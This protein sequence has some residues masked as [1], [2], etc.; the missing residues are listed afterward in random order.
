MMKFN[1]DKLIV[2]IKRL[3]MCK[4]R[5]T[6]N[7][8]YKYF[9]ELESS[10]QYLYTSIDN[11]LFQDIDRSIIQGLMPQWVCDGGRSPELSLSKIQYEKYRQKIDIPIVRK[12]IYYYDLWYIIAAVQDRLGAVEMFM[13]DFYK[14]IPFKLKYKE[15]DY[16]SAAR[17]CGKWETE[18]HIS[19]NGVFVS[20]AS[21]FDLLSKIAIEQAQYTKYGDFS[22]YSKMNSNGFL[23][24]VDKL[25][26][27]INSALTKNGMLFVANKN[28]RIIE[29][30]RNEYVHNGPWDFRCSVYNTAVDGFPADVIVYAP[31]FDEN[32]NLVSSGA[33]NKFYSQGNRMN[34]MLPELVKSVLEILKNTIDCLAELY[35]AST[36]QT[37]DAVR[38]KQCLEELKSCSKKES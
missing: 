10:I 5:I 14:S 15:K 13:Q 22:N 18:V 30:F 19:L 2:W 33:R 6:P 20:L 24:N 17:T 34:I 8:C 38:T 7:D 12:F 9:T 26:N 11:F 4:K 31:D 29:V 37:P 27:I 16:T 36:T 3:F 21:T 32:G 1:T 23:Y 35:I 28:V 25:K